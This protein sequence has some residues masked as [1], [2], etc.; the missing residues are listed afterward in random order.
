M[1]LTCWILGLHWNG[2]P[3]L[4]VLLL[5]SLSLLLSICSVCRFLCVCVLPGSELW[6][7]PLIF[8]ANTCT[9]RATER[10]RE[11]CGG[12]RREFGDDD[13]DDDGEE[14]ANRTYHPIQMSNF[15]YENCKYDE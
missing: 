9:H 7:D 1:Y 13:D 10:E 11:H 6:D 3:I 15:R 2:C 4:F 14:R 5:F 8:S 12:E